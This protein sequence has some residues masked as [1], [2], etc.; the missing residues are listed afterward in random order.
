MNGKTK[1]S[2]LITNIVEC[3]FCIF[4]GAMYAAAIKYFIFPAQVIMTGTEGISIAT[5]YFFDN[6][7]LF[8]GLYLFFQSIM[9][10]F[11]FRKIGFRFAF[12]TLLVIITVVGALGT[13]PEYKFAN[14]DPQ[15]ERIMLVIFGGHSCRSGQSDRVPPQFVDG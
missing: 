4:A 15:D 9:I 8:I 2:Y 11:A 14:P 1:S 7:N 3:C 10:I 12:R 13:L 6:Q 5:A